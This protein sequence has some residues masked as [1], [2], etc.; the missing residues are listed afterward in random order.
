[1][2]RI[3]ISVFLVLLFCSSVVADEFLSYPEETT[4]ATDDQTWIITDI[5]EVTEEFT[6]KRIPISG[7]VSMSVAVQADCS[8]ITSGY[9]I[10]SD[11]G[12]L[13]Y[14]DGDSVETSGGSSLNNLAAAADPAVGDDS[15][16][17][18]SVGSVWINTTDDKTFVCADATVGAAVWKQTS[19]SN[20]T[21][22]RCI[23]L[24]DLADGDSVYATCVDDFIA[25]EDITLGVLPDAV[26]LMPDGDGS[27]YYGGRIFLYSPDALA[28]EKD[29]YPFLGYATT[30]ATTGNVITVTF[31]TLMLVSRDDS[32][33]TWTANVDEGKIGYA[34]P[35]TDGAVTLTKPDTAS[36]DIQAVIKILRVDDA[37]EDGAGGDDQG[38]GDIFLT[39]RQ[40]IPVTVRPDE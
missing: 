10:D 32:Y 13:Y 23:S 29:T 19:V 4:P 39:I 33:A 18:Y 1:M 7:L 2:H 24:D 12:V 31:G 26:Y 14:W 6:T 37:A 38:D 28:T 17:G 16:D 11:T 25:G 36:D 34:S 30:S 21:G 20:Y 9:C 22:E 40:D 35:T 15:G 5:N 27:S 3:G 8:T